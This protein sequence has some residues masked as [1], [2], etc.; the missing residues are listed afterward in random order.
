[1]LSLSV[2]IPVIINYFKLMG[3]AK[4][5]GFPSAVVDV[6]EYEMGNLLKKGKC[7]FPLLDNCD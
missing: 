1:L 3:I 4:Y 7:A 5:G 6:I 2:V